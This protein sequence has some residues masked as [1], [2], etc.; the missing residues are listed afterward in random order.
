MLHGQVFIMLAA[1]GNRLCKL[2]I[3]CH[4]TDYCPI[5]SLK[6]FVVCII[7]FDLLIDSLS[8]I[9]GS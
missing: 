7:C 8:S 9:V 4:Y 6:T 5:A 3:G 1:P 2:Q